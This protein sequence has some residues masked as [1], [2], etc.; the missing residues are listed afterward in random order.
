MKSGPEN[1]AIDILQIIRSHSDLDT[2]FSILQPRLGPTQHASGQRWPA[3]TT[4]Y[5]DLE[6]ELMARYS[7]P[8]PPLQPFE[9]SILNSVESWAVLS[10]GRIS[11]T[12][13]EIFGL[14]TNSESNPFPVHHPIQRS[15]LVPGPCGERLQEL[16]MSFWTTVPIPSDLAAKV[17]L[18]YLQMDHPLLGTFDPDLFVKDL[19]NCETRYCSRFLLSALMYWGCMYSALDPTVKE[20]TLQFCEGAETCWSEGKSKDSFLTLART[21][22]LGLAYMGDGKNHYVLTYMSE[23]N[24]MGARLGLF[25]VNPTATT[26][27]TQAGSPELK[28]VIFYAAWGSFNWIVLVSLFYQQPGVSYPKYP[29]T[30]PIPGNTSH[31]NLDDSPEPV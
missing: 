2:A 8:F 12:D 15:A 13:S 1:L 4:K 19:V 14:P 27:K 7:L 25:G 9:S 23:A 28:S 10:T 18:L 20:Y 17:I 31:H 22:L 5:L 16:N 6:S 29:P 24:S 26:P 30:L 11:N 3:G 21:Q